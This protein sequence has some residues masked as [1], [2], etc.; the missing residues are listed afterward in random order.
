MLVLFTS[1]SRKG[2]DLGEAITERDS[3]PMLATYDV[4]SLISDSGLIRYRVVADE[5]LVYDRKNPSYWAFEKGVYL[6]KFDVDLNVETE[7]KADTAYYYDRTKLWELKGNVAIKNVE[8]ERFNTD[9]LFWD[10]RTQRVYSDRFIRIEQ[11][12]RTITGQGFESNQQM[13]VYTIFKPGGIFYV[14]E[15]PQS[16]V[17][18]LATPNGTPKTTKP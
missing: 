11:K 13:T 14:E 2:Q 1:C 18:S 16:S 12:D 8:G 17:D 3:L 6:E 9:Q 4:N 10:E 15:T 5:W 7:L